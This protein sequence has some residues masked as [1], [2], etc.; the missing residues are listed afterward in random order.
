MPIKGLLRVGMY[1]HIIFDTG[2]AI[3]CEENFYRVKLIFCVKETQAKF[4][5][6]ASLNIN[7]LAVYAWALVFYLLIAEYYDKDTSCRP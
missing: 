5:W 7:Q 2:S 1:W 4:L 6:E 3:V